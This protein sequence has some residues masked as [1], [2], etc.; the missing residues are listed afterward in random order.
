MRPQPEP[1]EP[2][3]HRKPWEWAAITQALVERGALREGARGVGFAVG[4]E[5]VVSLFASLGA[6]VIATDLPPQNRASQI[7]RRAAQHG[8]SKEDLFVERLVDRERFGS[9]VEFAFADMNK[10]WDLPEH[11]FDFV[12]SSCALEHLGGLEAGMRFVERSMRLLKPGGIAAHTTEYNVGSNHETVTRGP[13]V[14][15]RQQD[16]EL[17]DRRLRR[18]GACLAPLDFEAGDHEYDRL[19]DFAPF[20][21]HGRQHIKLLIDGHVATSML[22]VVIA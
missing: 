17:L 5:P 11:S 20:Y 1:G 3:Y 8:D 21:S 14:I 9:H 18:A 7:W 15:Y 6:H 2:D 12:W 13:G 16:I 10:A 22:L 4:T 19:F